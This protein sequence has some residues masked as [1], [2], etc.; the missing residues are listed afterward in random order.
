PTPSNPNRVIEP[1]VPVLE[2]G[3]LENPWII[4]DCL[5]LQDMNQHLD[6]NYIL[7][8]DIDCSE[9]ADFSPIGGKFVEGINNCAG[10]TPFTGSLNGNNYS[11]SNLSI[12]KMSRNPVDYIIC[13]ALFGAT[14][15]AEIFDLTISDANITSTNGGE[16]G[17]AGAGAFVGYALNS[18]LTNLKLVDS[19]VTSLY[20]GIVDY[21]SAG[22]IV[23]YSSESTLTNLSS[24]SSTILGGF[25]GGI[26]GN[27]LNSELADLSG[28]SLTIVGNFGSYATGGIIGYISNMSTGILLSNASFSGTVSGTNYAGGIVGAFSDHQS[29]VVVSNL[30]NTGNV[31]GGKCAGS[32]IGTSDDSS[33]SFTPINV[34]NWNS[35]GL[36]N[37]GNYINAD[38]SND[39]RYA[40]CPPSMGGGDVE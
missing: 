7:G 1:I 38:Y 6:G 11:I 12:N 32:L 18:T 40:G 4:N 37:G 29:D 10:N 9:I 8:N 14:S 16:Y 13:S 20:S 2:L 31:Y 26:V 17:V 19:N 30:I 28:I 24:T 3:T 33:S 34:T 39:P 15:G 22:G 5:E 23:G 36:V 25:A 21:Y 27:A 35:N